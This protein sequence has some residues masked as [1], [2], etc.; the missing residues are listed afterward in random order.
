MKRVFLLLASFVALRA[1]PE[2]V[3]V[4]ADHDRELFAL[5]S[6]PGDAV[7]WLRLGDSCG[8]YTI[9]EYQPAG[10]QLILRNGIQTLA[11]S[12]RRAAVQTLQLTEEEIIA[13]AAREIAQKENWGSRRPLSGAAP[14]QGELDRRGPARFRGP[15]DGDPGHRHDAIGRPAGLRQVVNAGRG[16][17]W[18]SSRVAR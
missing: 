9:A 11:L 17:D 1:E 10:E 2:F 12:L 5:S 8:D 14:V 3:G 6:R 16:T 4:F 15:A 18:R 7:R 13:Q